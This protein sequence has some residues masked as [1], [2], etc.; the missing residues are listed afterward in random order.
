MKSRTSAVTLE[1]APAGVGLRSGEAALITGASS[2]IGETFARTLAARGVSL[3]LSARPEEAEQLNAIVEELAAHH[4]VRCI[5]IPADLS[6]RAGADRVVAA[7]AEH[8]FEPDLLVNSAGV[9][10]AGRFDEL[11]SDAQMRMIDVNVA[12]LVRLTRAFL[13]AM[14]ARRAGGVIN[15]ASTAAFQPIPYFGVYSASKAFVLNFSQSL[16]AEAQ[17]DGV[18]VVAVCSGP[19]ETAFHGGPAS[20]EHGARG[21]VR[22][23]YMTP[24]HVV[25]AAL[26]ALVRNRP[27]VV[28]RL[29]IAGLL[30]HVATT[31]A[32]LL[33][34]HVR[35]RLAARAY[36]RLFQ[37]QD[38]T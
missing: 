13:P 22:R 1:Q 8:G 24:E 7:A 38:R 21:L 32:R 5:G 34:L 6:D 11:G 18:R 17:S 15:V 10:L 20:T 33:P 12:G 16:W 26:L 30:Y 31:A 9:G 3:L 4:G 37:I 2:G 35:L 19:V 27:L 25:D 23:R 28:L 14:A 36:R 29:P